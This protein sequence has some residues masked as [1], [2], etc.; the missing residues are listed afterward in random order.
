MK[1]IDIPPYRS[2]N[3]TPERGHYLLNEIIANM[4]QTGSA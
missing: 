2:V 4:R 3:Y 1:I